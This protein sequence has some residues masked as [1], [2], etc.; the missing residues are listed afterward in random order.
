[1]AESTSSARL[2]F[3]LSPE[4]KKVI[5]EAAEYTG[6]SVSDF[7]VATLLEK[8]RTVLQEL[9]VTKLTARDGKMLLKLLDD[10]TAKPND[11]LIRAVKKYEKGGRR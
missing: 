4:Q 7:A 9:Q 10:V 6:Q 2:N 8:S 5:E 3:R 11:A 1:M